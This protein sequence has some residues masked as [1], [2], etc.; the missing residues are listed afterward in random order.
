[1]L[2]KEMDVCIIMNQ[3]K[4]TTQ[5][6]MLNIDGSEIAYGNIRNMYM[7]GNGNGLQLSERLEHKLGEIIG[8]CSEIADKVYELQDIMGGEK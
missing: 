3:M 4:I 2:C 7:T 8:I 5:K 1:M 6:G